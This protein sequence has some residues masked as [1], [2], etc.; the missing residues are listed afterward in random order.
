MITTSKF[1]GQC[2]QCS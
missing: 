2:A 1:R